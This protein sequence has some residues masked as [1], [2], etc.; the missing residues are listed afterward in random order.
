MVS[1]VRD[2]PVDTYS[3]VSEDKSV[4]RANIQTVRNRIGNHDFEIASLKRHVTDLL[5]QEAMLVRRLADLE[6]RR[7]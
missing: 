5:E 4:I 6:K 2:H 3:E 1:E 7:R